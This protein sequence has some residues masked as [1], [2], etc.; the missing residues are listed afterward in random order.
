MIRR[1]LITAGLIIALA[2]ALIFSGGT[3][4]QNVI[5][6]TAPPGTSNNQCASTAFVTGAVA[7]GGVTINTTPITGGTN[8]GLLYDK[9]GVVGNLPT[10]NS[11]V[12]VTNGSGVPSISSTLPSALTIPSPAFTGTVTGANTIPLGIL[13]QSAANTM[14]GNWSG[15]T[16]N[17]SANTMPS[18]ADTGGNHLNYVSGTGVTCGTASGNAITALTGAVT[19]TGP[20]SVAATLATAQP[21]VHTWAL[22]QTF[23]VAPV[24]TDQSGSRTALGLGTAAVA[25]TGTSGHTLPFLDGNNTFSGTITAN[26]L[27][28]VGTIGGSLCATSGGLILYESG[29]NCFA[30]AAA[31]I[32]V[33]TTTVASGADKGIFYQNGTS[34]TGV[35]SQY[36]LTGTGTVAVMQNTPTLTTPVL[37]IA[38]GTSLALNGCTIG[39]NALCATGHLLI[40]GVTSTGAT[41]TG[42]FVFDTSPIL[43][44]P[45][46]GTPSAAVLT[47][48][49]GL[50]LTSGVTG[51]L[52]IVNGG[53]NA[54]SVAGCQANLGL[55]MTRSVV[56][57]VDFSVAGDNA[58]TVPLPTGFTRWRIQ[59]L[60]ISGASADISAANFGVHT[61]AGGTGFA[62]VADATAITVT[63]NAEDTNNNYMVV[64]G[65]VNQNTLSNTPTTIYFRVGTTAA[66]GR[67]GKVTIVFNP[68]S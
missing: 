24:F 27:S 23:T 46:L 64:A 10:G 2:V 5:C 63:T 59:L 7:I 56:T 60:T 4:A 1:V 67:T 30:A 34:P 35:I 21:A 16:A 49:T 14:L 25:T 26:A 19:A 17:V 28:T 39:G 18:C 9:A 50:P 48:A 66:A 32:T 44:T 45:N 31:S 40:E 57:T 29:V 22:A 3:K 47:S 11:G 15:S 12:L 58:I 36:T 68:L 42:K 43:V 20:G 52:P 38:T 51:T 6:P 33:G 13:A 62:I 55:A 65:I 61:G 8:N 41:G 37:G 54:T 53:C